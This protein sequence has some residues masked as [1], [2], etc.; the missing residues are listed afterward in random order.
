MVR[1]WQKNNYG[2]VKRSADPDLC[3]SHSIRPVLRHA[4]GTATMRGMLDCLPTGAKSGQN[5]LAIE[6]VAMKRV[7]I[8]PVTQ[9]RQ[10][11][12]MEVN[13]SGGSTA[14]LVGDTFEAR[15]RGAFDRFVR[16]FDRLRPGR[17]L[18]LQ[19]TLEEAARFAEGRIEALTAL[20]RSVG[21]KLEDAS[22]PLKIPPIAVPNPRRRKKRAR[23]PYARQL[24]SPDGKGFTAPRRRSR[25]QF[26]IG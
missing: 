6:P 14:A 11:P 23:S 21:T 24:V 12:G 5:H 1:F 18:H 4:M 13:A 16:L 10:F 25:Q 8:V 20:E 17:S 9:I 22:G 3:S 7:I 2:R 26:A 15:T 19:C